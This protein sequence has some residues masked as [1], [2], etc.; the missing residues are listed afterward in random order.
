MNKFVLTLLIAIVSCN[1][2]RNLA[3]FNFDTFY[4]A[5]VNRHNTLRKKH[6]AGKLTK[7]AAIAKLAQTTVNNCKSKGTL[8]HSGTS[9]NGQWMVKIYM[10]Q[11]VFLLVLML[12]IVGILK[13]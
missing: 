11:V 4:T 6:S 8:I 12:L 3:S 2:L 1:N 5:L 13:M 7:L 10:S 9:Y